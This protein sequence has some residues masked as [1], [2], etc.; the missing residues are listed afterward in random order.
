MAAELTCSVS[1]SLESKCFNL[2]LQH[3]VTNNLHGNHC[4]E[5]D[6]PFPSGAGAFRCT[7]N[8]W[9]MN[10]N[11]ITISVVVTRTNR[12]IRHNVP[13][14]HIDLPGKTGLPVP[15]DIM[16]SITRDAMPVPAA[17]DVEGG[18]TISVRCDVVERYCVDVDGHFTALCTIAVSRSWPPPPLPAPPTLGRDISVVAPDL[19][20]VSFRVEGETFAAHRLVLAARSPVFKAALYG[21]MAESKASSVVAIEDMRA[22]TFRSMLDYMYHGSLP[23]AVAAT[24]EIDDAALKE[25]FQHLYVAADRYGLDTLKEM[26]EEV[27]CARVSVSTVLSNLVFA[28]E[29]TCTK[30]KPRCLDFLAVGENFKEVAVT[31]EYFDMVMESPG[32]L[33]EVQ[34]WFK[35]PR[36][37]S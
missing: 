13:A 19:A 36:L 30:L 33:A 8:Y 10:C 24:L 14:A 32:L 15:H 6:V 2:R 1:D 25:E 31:S 3:S 7:A 22:P 18:T 20:D 37:S 11:R 21:E 17:G 29:R 28:E 34:N 27:L 9:P 5:T 35:R 12:Q 4:I 23:V 26:C 16:A